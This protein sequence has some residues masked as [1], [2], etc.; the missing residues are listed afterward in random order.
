M[1]EGPTILSIGVHTAD[2]GW[3]RIFQFA[4]GTMAYN[5]VWRHVQ[6]WESDMSVYYDNDIAEFLLRD[7]APSIVLQENLMIVEYCQ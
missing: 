2:D 3:L 6:H 7:Y 1:K 5:D 4:K